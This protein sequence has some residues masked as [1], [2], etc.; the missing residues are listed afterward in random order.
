[1]TEKQN[2]QTQKRLIW[3][4]LTLSAI[5]ALV[6]VIIRLW[7]RRAIKKPP[8]D[9]E[10]TSHIVYEGIQGLT[11]AEAE[12]RRMEGQ[13]N[14]ISFDPPRTMKDILRD[15]VL[16]IFNLSLLGVA[17]VQFLLGLFLDG[18]LSLGVSL[19]AIGI[20]VGQE[21]FVRKML[22]DVLKST[23]PM[24]TVIREN[25]AKSIDPSEIVMGDAL[26]VGPGDQIMVDGELLSEKPIVVN[27]SRLMGE[28]SHLTKRI[29][30][31]VYAGSFCISGRGAYRAQKVGN[32]RLVAQLIQNAP[33]AQKVLT[34]LEK[35]V[36][37][38]LS[39]MLFIVAILFSVLLVSYFRIDELVG[40]SVDAV[41]SAT[42]VIFSLAPAGLYFMI[43]LNYVSGTFQLAR[44]G[45]LAPRAR[46]VETLAHATD[47]CITQ[48]STRAGVEV[49]METIEQ[50]K[51]NGRLADSRVRQ[52]LGDYGR[53]SS[54]YNQAVMALADKFP[55][56]SRVPLAEA[57]F[58]SA[59]GWNA[60]VFDDDDLR[61]VYVLGEPQVLEGYLQVIEV[62]DSPDEDEDAGEGGEK[63]P[64]TT[65]IREGI[66]N[67]GRFFRRAETADEENKE[68]S[69][70]E[71]EGLE[72]SI[73]VEGEVDNDLGELTDERKP[74]PF[75][76]LVKRISQTF[77]R[78]QKETEQDGESDEAPEEVSSDEWV[79]QFAYCPDITPLHDD[80]GQPQL[81]PDLIPLCSLNYSRQIRPEMI[82]TVR[83]F[84]DTGVDLKV[85]SP[86]DPD[87]FIAVLEKAGLDP[88]ND[89]LSR[90]INGSE[91]AVLDREEFGRVV[92]EKTI[93]G[94]G[95][96]E[97]Y[98]Q[99]VKS[100]RDHGKTV[101]VV[102]GGPSDLQIMQQANLSIATHGGSQTAIS[103]ADIILLKESPKVML[104]ALEGGQIIVNG[105]LDV[106]KLYLTQLLY[107]VLLILILVG[108]GLGFPYVAKQGTLI[109]I[110]T[111]TLPSLGL[112]L[113]AV[114]GAPPRVKKLS[115][116]LAW[117]V[118][119]AALAI[120]AAGFAIYA[121]FLN[122]SGEVSYAQ[123]GLTY[124][125]VVSGLA[126]L[127]LVRPPI[128]R[129]RNSSPVEDDPKGRD[130]PGRD[131]RPTIL[132]LVVLVLLYIIAP[133]E[134]T[135]FL[136]EFDALQ[137]SLDYL[138]IG[139]A[140]LAWV[141]AVELFWRFIIPK[142][143]RAR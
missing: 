99:V 78:G 102:G 14:D 4:T 45:A 114:P 54:S 77:Q 83:A 63:R 104:K 91:L 81:P 143:Y 19:L 56:D 7:R 85:F 95:S 13:D 116:Y 40:V 59:Y 111:L 141:V 37:R 79:Y 138:V 119:P 80:T 11:E 110:A 53:S 49:R 23:R 73:K 94:N 127:I 133:W 68:L 35:I 90:V 109:A 136:F 87:R 72:S 118:G 108:A 44:L 123:L 66:S 75:Q 71:V 20:Q 29:G 65:N 18:L 9:L 21:L 51:E 36:A 47:I 122:N 137:Q 120:S 1:M 142:G 17:S 100:L 128:Q 5:A 16:T 55:G 31:P 25:Q 88:E 12:S 86:G 30:D 115:R 103:V 52:I 129:K 135:H 82:E 33:P 124:L 3:G 76:G 70:L 125:L 69:A 57:P 107:L 113:W 10:P 67:L 28:G 39:V 134:L 62:D 105:L 140:V 98:S 42:S 64:I 74:N 48:G 93:F 132:V 26:V 89:E 32:E 84:A 41:V 60:M 15:N 61:G 6:A 97:Q 43:F 101:T 106:L 112:S 117:F 8:V 22:G 130:T 96:P 2:R 58:L 131:W 50:G 139:V 121:Y 126:L 34:P 46:S 24:A 27:E 38:V 92:E